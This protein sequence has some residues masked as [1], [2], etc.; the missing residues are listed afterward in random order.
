MGRKKKKTSKKARNYL[1]AIFRWFFVMLIRC[2]PLAVIAVLLFIGFI[3]IKKYLYADD[4]FVIT[5][6]R[7]T[8]DRVYPKEDVALRGNITSGESIFAIDVKKIAAALKADSRVKDVQVR[9]LFPNTL[10]I[11]MSIRQEYAY[12]TMPDKQRF[13]LMDREGYIISLH[14]VQGLKPEFPVIV[15]GSTLRKRIPLGSKHLTGNVSNS[16]FVLEYLKSEG[17]FATLDV[18]E[19]TIDRLNSL[20][21][22]IRDGLEIKLGNTRLIENMQ[23]LPHVIKIFEDEKNVKFKYIDLRFDDIIVKK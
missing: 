23:K 16:F 18:R 22:I 10:D 15:D 20:S 3:T 6:L 8:T 7:I 5:N 17:Y 12:L 13:Y 19:I 4:Y 1:F 2:I 9:K 21:L 14:D 11:T